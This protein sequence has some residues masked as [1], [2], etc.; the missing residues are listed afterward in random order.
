[1]ATIQGV[2][3][4]LFGRPADPLG[5][6]FFNAQTN[7]GANLAGIGPLQSSAEFQT[8][9]AGQSNVQII[10]S[11]Y[12][13][14]FN[15]AADLPGL[16][17]FSNALANGTLTIN[18]IAIAIYDGAQGADKT[19]RDLREAAANAFTA[20]I[21]TAQEVVGYNGAAAAASGAAF[22]Q[23]ITTTAPT[24]VQVDAAVATATSQPNSTIT[25]NL[26]STVGENIAGTAANET[27]NGVVTGD[28]SAGSTLN[29][30][31]V[32][33]G[34][35]GTDT[36]NIIY[37][38]STPAANAP[39]TGLPAG[40]S[41]SGVEIVNLNL[42]ALANANVPTTLTSATF[43]GVQQLWQID[44]A[45]GGATSQNVTVGSGVTAGFRG[46]GDALA[47]T[48]TQSAGASAAV[49]ID[50]VTTGGSIVVAEGT[51]GALKTISLSGSV[52]ANGSVSVS[53]AATTVDTFN[54]TISSNSAVG[55][56]TAVGNITKVVSFA[57]ST[58]DVTFNSTALGTALTTLTGGSG[59]DSLVASNAVSTAAT[60]T[61]DG[62][63][64]NDTFT[65]NVQHSGNAGVVNLTG[66]AGADTFA[67]NSNGGAVGN[68]FTVGSTANLTANLVTITDFN[69]AE[70]ILNISAVGAA[71]NRA[72]QNTVNA[73]VSGITDLQAAVTAVAA[74]TA[75]NGF[76]VFQ[77][78]AD[79]YIYDDT[80]GAGGYNA[81]DTLI[82]LTGV[83]ATALTGS[84]FIG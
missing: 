54:A 1:M 28:G 67:L 46:A 13:S 81:G 8:R 41:V 83:T 50:G 43:A 27:I 64:G 82:K 79:T 51:A 61:V 25:I 7:N 84:N 71:G 12:Q 69:A 42:T 73:A 14:L 59:K 26:T 45:V 52:A 33:N 19:I 60:L 17:F 66:G 30:G 4:A 77:L 22:I 5:L 15:R 2:Y 47:V 29:I 35:A 65:F 23:G 53:T 38:P 70:D 78:G 3:L 37:A 57:G 75:A 74:V 68:L 11:I 16:T 55:Y 62:G 9:F 76:A 31:D 39:A 58:G 40:A 48:V 49:A 21:D 10:N 32:I 6:A 20:A 24:A 34:G 72:V 18:N 44:T 80:T 56:N 36:L 63:A